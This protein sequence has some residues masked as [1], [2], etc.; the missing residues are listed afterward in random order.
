MIIGA[1]AVFVT[2]LILLFMSIS[3]KY[4]SLNKAAY[5]AL[6]LLAVCVTAKHRLGRIIEALIA[7]DDM[8][9]EAFLALPAVVLSCVAI[10]A[11]VLILRL[12]YRSA[13]LKKEKINRV[14]LLFEAIAFI[15]IFQS[16][17][18]VCRRLIDYDAT[19][20][21]DSLFGSKGRFLLTIGIISALISL[22]PVIVR[23][24]RKESKELMPVLSVL[25]KSAGSVLLFIGIVLVCVQL[26]NNSLYNKIS[27][28]TFVDD[29]SGSIIVTDDDFTQ[30][31]Y[32]DIDMLDY[33]ETDEN[34]DYYF[35]RRTVNGSTDIVKPYFINSEVVFIP[36]LLA[37]VCLIS[38]GLY[39]S[40]RVKRKKSQ[41]ALDVHTELAKPHEC[42][43]SGQ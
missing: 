40:K 33:F 31:F 8:T 18:I 43:D 30:Y 42:N 27:G 24:I 20:L 37:G 34:G 11:A 38:A 9:D 41:A 26:N 15:F 25:F 10:S 17:F 19:V 1:F 28:V 3:K 16:A 29:G 23:A 2:E 32:L 21:S 4:V 22:V 7:G 13:Y 39:L 6:G 14:V 12:V 36:C 5:S 35:Y